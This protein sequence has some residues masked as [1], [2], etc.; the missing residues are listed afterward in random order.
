[1]SIPHASELHTG[2]L[3]TL[4]DTPLMYRIMYSHNKL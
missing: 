2:L 4:E 1:M 3:G